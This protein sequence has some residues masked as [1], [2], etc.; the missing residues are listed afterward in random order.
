MIS[1]YFTVFHLA[2][3]HAKVYMGAR[4]EEKAR[5]AIESIKEDI[6]YAEIEFLLMD[7]MD[8]SSVVAASKSILQKESRLHGIVNNAGI[9]AVPQQTSKDG[10][11]S[12]W[13]VW[14]IR[15]IW[16]QMKSWTDLFLKRPT[17]CPI[18]C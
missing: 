5:S 1:G 3:H 13:Q 12:Q 2:K 9:M 18:G 15:P 4:N 10:Y 16:L 14:L 17:T 8:L 11:E 7:M 6:P